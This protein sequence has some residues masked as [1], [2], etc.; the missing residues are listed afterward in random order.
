[1]NNKRGG[2]TNHRKIENRIRRRWKRDTAGDS[3]GE[4]MQ[5]RISATKKG[6]TGTSMNEKKTKS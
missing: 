4:R 3:K 2:C 5:P 1:M 6:F